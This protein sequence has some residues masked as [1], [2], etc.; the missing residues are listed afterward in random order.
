MVRSVTLC[1][2]AC[3]APGVSGASE[4]TSDMLPIISGDGRASGAWER[5][6]RLKRLATMAAAAP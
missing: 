2:T 6:S 1:E 4:L 5:K 3:A